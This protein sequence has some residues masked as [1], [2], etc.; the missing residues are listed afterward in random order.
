M[1]QALH[2]LY[3]K[4]ENVV[5]NTRQK[6]TLAHQKCVAFVLCILYIV[7]SSNPVRWMIRILKQSSCHPPIYPQTARSVSF[8]NNSDPIANHQSWA[9]SC[10]SWCPR[11]SELPES[12]EGRETEVS[13]QSRKCLPLTHSTSSD[14][15]QNTAVAAPWLGV[16][17]NRY[18]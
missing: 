7:I 11:V 4:R 1:W 3:N 14:T 2:L 6:L 12:Q 8:Y 16:R 5:L 9:P 13:R 15:A 17:R 18:I 10:W